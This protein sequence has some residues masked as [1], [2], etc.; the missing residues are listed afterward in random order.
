MEKTK[1]KLKQ[2]VTNQGVTLTAD[3]WRQLDD[4]KFTEKIRKQK[5]YAYRQFIE[6]LNDPDDDPIHGDDL[7]E[8]FQRVYEA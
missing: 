4:K 6:R 5:A 8:Q 2:I 1:Q 7:S 3:Q